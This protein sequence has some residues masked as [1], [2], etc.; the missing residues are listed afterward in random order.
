MGGLRPSPPNSKRDQQRVAELESGVGSVLLRLSTLELDRPRG[1]RNKIFT[2]GE[3]DSLLR[4]SYKLRELG[5]E[6]MEPGGPSDVAIDIARDPDGSLTV[7]PATAI[8]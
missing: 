8:T 5:G 2:A 6:A 1:L 3:V 4:A 7:F